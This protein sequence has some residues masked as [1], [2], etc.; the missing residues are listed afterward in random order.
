MLS[1]AALA[2]DARH[3]AALSFFARCE[4]GRG[5]SLEA[6]KLGR[7]LTDSLTTRRITEGIE[8]GNAELLAYLNGVNEKELSADAVSV[9]NRLLQVIENYGGPMQ[10]VVG[11]LPNTGKTNTSLLL[12]RL[13][14]TAY[15]DGQIWT[16]MSSLTWSDTFVRSANDLLDLLEDHADAPHR[17]LIILD[18]GSTWFDAT[19]YG[20]EVRQQWSPLTKR[21]AKFGEGVDSINV[22]HTL[23]DLC[24]AAL[25]VATAVVWKE[26]QTKGQWYE[27]V[28]PET[29]ELADPIFPHTLEN[30]EKIPDRVYDPDDMSPWRWDL[31]PDRITSLGVP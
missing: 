16:N 30:I 4:Q 13:W 8:E 12:A 2:D 10:I 23:T 7:E 26:T 29:R 31:D 9:L 25:R 6:S 19:A 15:P 11:G 14:Q 5:A 3:E 21:F 20:R 28:D 24:P 18:E 17:I 22:G 27:T 1:T